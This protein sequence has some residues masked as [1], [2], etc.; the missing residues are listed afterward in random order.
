MIHA[1]YDYTPFSRSFLTS[2][3]KLGKK[4]KSMVYISNLGEEQGKNM[5]LFAYIYSKM[6]KISAVLISIML[7]FFQRAVIFKSAGYKNGNPKDR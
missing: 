1:F 5:I 2:L 7:M 4:L 6:V 3:L